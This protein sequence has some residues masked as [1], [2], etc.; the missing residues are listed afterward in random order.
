MS[1]AKKAII[2]YSRIYPSEVLP[3]SSISSKDKCLDFDLDKANFITNFRIKNKHL[4]NSIDHTSHSDS[5]HSDSNHS[6]S[7]HNDISFVNNSP[8]DYY[9]NIMMPRD[10]AKKCV[11]TKTYNNSK[12]GDSYKRDSSKIDDSNIDY[13]NNV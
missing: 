1:Y 10:F 12:V 13:C 2:K 8:I 11:N 6:D 9:D 7:N 5:N 4:E 3:I